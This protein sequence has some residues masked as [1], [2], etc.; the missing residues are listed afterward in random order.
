M[1]VI[2]DANV[3]ISYL[4]AKSDSNPFRVLIRAATDGTFQLFLSEKTIDEFSGSVARKPHLS[5]NITPE[6]VETFI[7]LLRVIADV[8][9]EPDDPIQ[10]RT[11]DVKDDYLVAHAIRTEADYLVTGDKDLREFKHDRAFSIV[12]PATFMTILERGTI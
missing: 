9:P 8:S 2:V 6:A 3:L 12:T 10:I 1:K 4:L 7:S 5:K 11:R